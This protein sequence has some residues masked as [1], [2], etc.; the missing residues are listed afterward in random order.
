MM[1]IKEESISVWPLFTT[2]SKDTTLFFFAPQML[3]ILNKYAQ[4][5]LPDTIHNA[6]ND[7][8]HVRYIQMS[9]F[10]GVSKFRPYNHHTGILSRISLPSRKACW[11]WAAFVTD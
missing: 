3:N 9:G 5:H 6:I 7:Y 4:S 8:I 2:L 11:S 1:V 10:I